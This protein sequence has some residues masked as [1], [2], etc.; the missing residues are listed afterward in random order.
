MQDINH[1]EWWG[2]LYE[3]EKNIKVSLF[4]DNHYFNNLVLEIDKTSLPA[5]ICS[6][7]GK[8]G[9][10]LSFGQSD[11]VA[12]TSKSAVMADAAATAIANT[13]RTKEDIK[14]Q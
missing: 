1:R 6:S 7:S 4:L 10:S 12:V 3:R 11:L 2:Y 9:H 5:S 8:I 13:V 14:G